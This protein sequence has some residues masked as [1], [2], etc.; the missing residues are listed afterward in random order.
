MNNF[1]V[2]CKVLIMS[3]F[4]TKL[5]YAN[6]FIIPITSPSN[7]IASTVVNPFKLICLK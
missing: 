5:K 1:P 7:D 2:S 3:P 4:D 6:F